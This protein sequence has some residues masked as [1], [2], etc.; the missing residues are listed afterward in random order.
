MLPHKTPSAPALRR[1]PAPCDNGAGPQAHA[2]RS[3]L[4]AGLCCIINGAPLRSVVWQAAAGAA[5]VAPV[6]GRP[7]HAV[8]PG[9][10]NQLN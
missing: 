7:R 2:V 4:D 9:F 5:V 10:S 3:Q 8:Q 6:A 1:M